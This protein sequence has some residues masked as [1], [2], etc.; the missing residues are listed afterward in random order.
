MGGFQHAVLL[1][2]TKHR[3]HISEITALIDYFGDTE[4]IIRMQL[5]S[6][7]EQSSVNVKHNSSR[8]D[9]RRNNTLTSGVSSRCRSL[10]MLLFV[11]GIHL[12]RLVSP[13]TNDK[14]Q[15]VRPDQFVVKQFNGT[16]AAALACS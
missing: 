16:P 7:R 3:Q 11:A 13:V 2:K 4:N 15:R 5:H 9:N 6:S 1:P 8:E 12:P 14:A 10:M